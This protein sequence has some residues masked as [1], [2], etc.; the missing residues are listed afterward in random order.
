MKVEKEHF[1][2]STGRREYANNGLVSLGEDMET[3][4]GYDGTFAN[5]LPWD[6]DCEPL[7]QAEREELADYQIA[8]WMAYKTAVKP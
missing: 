1:V 3:R 8:L 2:F 7:T 6:E 5:D 4:Q